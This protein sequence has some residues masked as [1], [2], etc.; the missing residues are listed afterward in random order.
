[1]PINPIDA[2]RGLKIDS[3]LGEDLICRSFSGQEGLGRLFDYRL[4]LLSLDLNIQFKDIV[5]QRVTVSMELPEGER[6][7]DG[8]VSEFRYMGTSGQFAW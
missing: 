4:D 6:H 3:P 7:F 1:M 5:G 8:Y 2:N